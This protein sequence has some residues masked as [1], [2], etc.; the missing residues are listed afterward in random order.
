MNRLDR[1]VVNDEC[2]TLGTGI[3]K[4]LGRVKGEVQLLCEFAGRITQKANLSRINTSNIISMRLETT[5]IENLSHTLLF[6]VGSRAVPQAF[7]LRW[8][9]VSR[10]RKPE[11]KAIYTNA[12]LTEITNT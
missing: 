2:V 10:S 1:S 12:S 3:A 6:P 8:M 11:F 5:N 9:S 4:D 7:M